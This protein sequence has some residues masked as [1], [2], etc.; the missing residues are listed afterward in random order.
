MSTSVVFLAILAIGFSVSEA[1]VFERCEFA[2]QLLKYGV[3]KSQIPTWTCIARHESEFDTSKINHDTGDHGILQIS[4]IY[5]CTESGGPG[6]ACKKTCADF[7][8]DYLG[9]DIE[10]AKTIYNEHQRL[11]GNGFNAWV[12]FKTHCSGDNSK[13]V[14]GCF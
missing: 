2:H 6:K 10:C 4:Q 8:N 14:E 11:S 1:K 13:F 7:R 3:P 5:W 12:V 9:D